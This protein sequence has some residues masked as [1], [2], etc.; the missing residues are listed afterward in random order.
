MTKTRFLP[1]N[2][3]QIDRC[4]SCNNIWLDAGEQALLLRLYAELLATQPDLAAIR[5]PH[6]D[7]LTHSQSLPTP[8]THSDVANIAWN[9][10]SALC[11]ILIDMLLTPSGYRGRRW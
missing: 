1:T 6:L 5:Q 8:Y 10:G 11:Y 3:V 7:T 2:P 9:I 4:P